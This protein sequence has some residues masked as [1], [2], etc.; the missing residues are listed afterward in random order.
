MPIETVKIVRQDSD[1]GFRIIAKSDFDPD[2]HELF[3][4]AAQ[5][6]SDSAPEDPAPDAEAESKKPAAKGRTRKPAAEK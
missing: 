5:T 6:S 4:E 2:L 1:R 3:E